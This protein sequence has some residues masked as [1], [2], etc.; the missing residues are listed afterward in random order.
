MFLHNIADAQRLNKK[1]NLHTGANAMI[2]GKDEETSFAMA[3]IFA[4]FYDG[5][6][7][8]LTAQ[9]LDVLESK[10]LRG[11]LNTEKFEKYRV[12]HPELCAGGFRFLGEFGVEGIV[13]ITVNENEA[14]VKLQKAGLNVQM[15]KRA[16]EQKRFHNHVVAINDFHSLG[17]AMKAQQADRQREKQRKAVTAYQENRFPL[18]DLGEVTHVSTFVES[19]FNKYLNDNSMDLGGQT[20]KV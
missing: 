18:R 17:I 19:A 20:F 3:C 9:Q 6:K 2:D 7:Q 12:Q 5:W 14:N 8:L 15:A 16:K 4:H 13:T 11:Y 10:F 1:V